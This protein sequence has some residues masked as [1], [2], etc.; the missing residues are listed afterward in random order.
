MLDCSSAGSSWRV[1]AAL[2]MCQGGMHQ[3]HPQLYL[4][5]LS[6]QSGHRPSLLCHLLLG[7]VFLTCLKSIQI[8]W[9]FCGYICFPGKCCLTRLLLGPDNLFSQRMCPSGVEGPWAFPCRLAGLSH[10]GIFDPRCLPGISSN[11]VVSSYF[12]FTTSCY[13]PA[14]P[15][16]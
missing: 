16:M 11:Q 8:L 13:G 15:F 2:F 10:L 4:V 3:L 7:V 9:Y 14:L 12:F 5:A 1:P 6:H